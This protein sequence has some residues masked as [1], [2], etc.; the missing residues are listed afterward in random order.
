MKTIL[1]LDA[2]GVIID[3][4]TTQFWDM[5]VA[6]STDST[7]SRLTIYTDYKREVSEKLWSG[8]CNEQDFV[9]FLKHYQ[10]NLSHE[11][12]SEIVAK[13]LIPLPAFEM[14]EIWSTK[15]E[16][17]IMSNHR[18]S[19][20][21]PALEAVRPYLSDIY[22]SDTAQ[23]K[24]PSLNWFNAI[25]EKHPNSSILFVDNTMHNIEAARQSGWQAIYADETYMWIDEVNELLSKL[26][27]KL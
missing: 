11:L 3:D 2:G 24:K 4:L 1:I 6:K 27:R 22:V 17:Y 5:L 7:L 25:S 18:T 19:W 9:Q 14:L 13:C 12:L 16:L 10:I 26:N 23:M 20:L 21:L 15:V 8:Q